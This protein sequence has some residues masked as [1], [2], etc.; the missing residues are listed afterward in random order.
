MPEFYTTWT[1]VNGTCFVTPSYASGHRG[2]LAKKILELDKRQDRLRER[3]RFTIADSKAKMA[4]LELDSTAW[5]Y[6]LGRNQAMYDLWI[7]L[8]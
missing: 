7:G 5:H 8:E 6:Q 4:K 1:G 2:D 3:A